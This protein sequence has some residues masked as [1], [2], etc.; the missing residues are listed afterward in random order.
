MRIADY[1]ERYWD[2]GGYLPPDSELL[3][4]KREMVA[5]AV[6]NLGQPRI[7]DIGCGDGKVSEGLAADGTLLGA[8][9]AATALRLA[10]ER[11]LVP[12]RTGDGGLPFR[13]SCFNL[14]LA[15][16]VLEHL[17]DPGALLRECRRVLM[18]RGVLLVALP[19]AGMILNRLHFLATGRFRDFTAS[20]DRIMPECAIQEHIRFFNRASALALLARCGF[21]ARVTGVWFP[22]RFY[23]PGLQRWSFV[24]AALNRLG[25]VR[26]APGLLAQVLFIEAGKAVAE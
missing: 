7:L 14:V 4:I 19:N 23:R 9:I 25:L 8:D 11:G 20:G 21:A 22:S 26:A 2:R 10:R 18:P 1:Y 15:F 24:G 17:F 16:D 3:V 5:R 6:S 12:V 13:D